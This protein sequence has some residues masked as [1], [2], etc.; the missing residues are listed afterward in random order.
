L[1]DQDHI[2]NKLIYKFNHKTAGQM[3]D[4]SDILVEATQEN[5]KQAVMDVVNQRN[6][7]TDNPF[8]KELK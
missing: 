6:L 5:I 7:N 1:D 2:W 4:Y 3:F 8:Y